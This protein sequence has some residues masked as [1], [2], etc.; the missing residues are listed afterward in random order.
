MK[1]LALFLLSFLSFCS[2]AQS[3]FI[4]KFG[5]AIG[6]E[7]TNHS[8]NDIQSNSLSQHVVTGNTGVYNFSI[9]AP[10]LDPS[11]TGVFTVASSS[12]DFYI[13]SYDGDGNFLN[14]FSVGG[15]GTD[16]CNSIAIDASNNILACGRF[17]GTV[18]FD[19]S[20]ATT[21]MVSVGGDDIFIAK[22][23]AAGSLIWVRTFGS[24]GNDDASKVIVDTQGNV[25]VSG[26]FTG[27]MDVDPGT[28]VSNLISQGAN[29][30]WFAKFTASGNLLRAKSFGG[31]GN[32]TCSKIAVKG[33]TLL[34][35]GLFSNTVDFD[36]SPA[37]Q[38]LTNVG[39][40][41]D[42]YF[43]N[44]DTTSFSFGWVKQLAGS[45]TT[46]PGDLHID[47]SNNIIITGYAN[48][49]SATTM[50]MDPGSGVSSFTVSGAAAYGYLAKYDNSGNLFW[51]GAISSTNAN[52][53]EIFTAFISAWTDNTGAIYTVGRYNGTTDFDFSSSTYTFSAP[54]GASSTF[55]AKYS[56]AGVVLD[57][58]KLTSNYSYVKAAHQDAQG[59][60]LIAGSKSGGINIDPT[61]QNP[62]NLIHYSICSNN[63][64]GY[65]AKY[66]SCV[67]PTLTALS[68]LNTTVC[69]GSPVTLSVTGVLNGA[70]NW[71]WRSGSC[72]GS[73]LGQGSSITV[74]PAANTNYFVKGYGG[75]AGKGMVCTSVSVATRPQPNMSYTLSQYNNFSASVCPNT[76]FTLGA[77]GAVTYTWSNGTV[78]NTA[79]YVVPGP[80]TISVVGTGTNGCERILS[81]PV[82]TKPIATLSISP[83]ISIDQASICPG[84][85]FQLVASGSDSNN[86]NWYS[87]VANG[88]VLAPSYNQSNT[89]TITNIEATSVFTVTSLNLNYCYSQT[90][91]TVN[92]L[93][94][95]GLTEFQNNLNL[96]VYP[97]PFS[98]RLFV[99][100]NAPAIQENSVLVYTA[101]GQLVEIKCQLKGSVLNLDFQ[102]DLSPGMYYVQV[103]TQDG[104]KLF[105]VLKD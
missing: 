23:S 17:Q 96:R 94:C 88:S 100:L 50:D 80:S 16:A 10:D 64:V 14:A 4:A 73:V 61:G 11:P 69:A 77:T 104:N 22:Y 95:V 36:P 3:Q 93:P 30:A 56:P 42:V 71:S 47:N 105:K 53:G 98:N 87:S 27:T 13:A 21:T 72:G 91:F 97:N 40:G 67:T 34:L 92:V 19:P 58:K 99:E 20:S 32:E 28:A 5:E 103:K 66:N 63:F 102:P 70:A 52:S 57:I 1:Y 78:S 43:S 82:N 59:S 6:A 37:T 68:P 62:Y 48:G 85:S 35:L 24:T 26:I 84:Y 55:Y 49:N 45:I 79:V 41:A 9:P 25:Y 8:C 75:C 60:L 81:I 29:D 38:T 15:S 54:S 46:T 76:T 65:Y 2:Q 83:I 18:D 74:T 90:S 33:N 51:A 101:F 89:L 31:T 86:Y 12:Q 44:F 39:T 7:C